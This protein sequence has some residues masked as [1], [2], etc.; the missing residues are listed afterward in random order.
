LGDTFGRFRLFRL[1]F[2]LLGLGW[3][4]FANLAPNAWWVIAGF[5][6]TYG[7]GHAAHTVA[8]Q[9]ILADYF[10]PRRYATISG[11]MSP[12]SLAI[13]VIGPLYGGIMFDVFG[14]YYRAFMIMGPII[15]MATFAMF[16]AGT[17]TMS[18]QPAAESRSGGH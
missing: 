9:A 3:V 11:I 7:F 16:W 13:S 8:G 18:G 2:L 17:P 12:M 4:F 1:S 14:S 6:V 5:F 10:G 15:A